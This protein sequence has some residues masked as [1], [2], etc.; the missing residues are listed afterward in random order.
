MAQPHL[1]RGGDGQRHFGADL[2]AVWFAREAEPVDRR[3]KALVL[4]PGGREF[5]VR[6]HAIHDELEATLVA[7]LVARL[8]S[9]D[10]AKLI[11]LPQKLLFGEDLL[12]STTA[13]GE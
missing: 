3:A 7:R 8:G 2:R 11:E 13:M 6:L 1:P 10:H 9:E 12:L 4:T 5:L